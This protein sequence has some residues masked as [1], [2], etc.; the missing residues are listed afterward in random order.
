MGEHPLASIP[1]A[2]YGVV[3][4]MAGM[5]YLV[6][7]RQILRSEGPDG[8]LAAALGRDIKGKVSPLLCALAI[9]AAFVHPGIAYALYLLVAF[10]SAHSR[11]SHRAGADWGPG[12]SDS[13]GQA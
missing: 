4:L 7:Q 3:L 9:G 2:L 1:T 13:P 6:L 12:R 10:M 8:I 5:A 11:S